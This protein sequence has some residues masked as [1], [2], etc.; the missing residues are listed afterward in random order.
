MG[1]LSFLSLLL[2]ARA[3]ITEGVEGHLQCVTRLW[4]YVHT[5]HR[6]CVR[7]VLSS[8]QLPGSVNPSC[9]LPCSFHI[10]HFKN[11][12]FGSCSCRHKC[13]S[14][15]LWHHLYHRT[16]RGNSIIAFMLWPKKIWSSLYTSCFM[17]IDWPRNNSLL[18][19]MA[20]WIKT[21]K[22][23]GTVVVLIMNLY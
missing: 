11:H 14:V 18:V 15:C 2:C 21:R 16:P 19:K 6:L 10:F 7:Y 23:V 3:E 17:H 12:Y 13:T 5:I 22:C 20:Q 1:L 9:Y 8:V 4:N